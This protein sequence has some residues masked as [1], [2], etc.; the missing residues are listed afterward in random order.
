M[1]LLKNKKQYYTIN[2]KGSV[3][4]MKDAIVSAWVDSGAKTGE[5]PRQPQTLDIMTDAELNA[6]LEHSYKQAAAGIGRPF[7]EAFDDLEKELG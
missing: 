1:F 2:G 7:W 4:T 3:I 5:I 6:K